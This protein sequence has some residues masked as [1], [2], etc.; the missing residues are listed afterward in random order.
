MDIFTGMEVAVLLNHRSL[1]CISSGT[2]HTLPICW[3]TPFGSH[4]VAV[5]QAVQQFGFAAFGSVFHKLE[6]D[7]LNVWVL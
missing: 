7:V 6:H 2:D 1:A 4:V 3:V 5:T